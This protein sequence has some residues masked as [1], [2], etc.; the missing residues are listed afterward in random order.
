[1]GKLTDTVYSET[2]GIYSLYILLIGREDR[3]R[4][5][6]IS[7]CAVVHAAS[8]HRED[9]CKSIDSCN[10]RVSTTPY[11]TLATHLG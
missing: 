8:S 1:M 6:G 4:S 2:I 11:S 9:G 5:K 7:R 10:L 3:S